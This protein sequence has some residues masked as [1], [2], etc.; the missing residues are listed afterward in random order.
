MK[1]AQV[2]RQP[3]KESVKMANYTM[4][5]KRGERP[6]KS[7]LNTINDPEADRPIVRLASG[8][9]RQ[10][11]S[12]MAIPHTDMVKI[13][14]VADWS[15]GGRQRTLVVPMNLPIVGWERALRMAKGE[16]LA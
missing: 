10:V 12:V 13:T 15:D 2:I 3:T 14:T 6:L 16:K 4:A 1:A 7:A 8:Q 5:K 11:E 9:E